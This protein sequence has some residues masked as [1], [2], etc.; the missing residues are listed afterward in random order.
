M[1]FFVYFKRATFIVALFFQMTTQAAPTETYRDLIE[2]AYNLSLQKDRSQATSI[3][4]NALKRETRPQA[5]KELAAALEQVAKVFYSEKGQQLYELA[6]SLKSTDLGLAA[7]KFQ[8]ANR[9]EPENVAIEI[10]SIRLLMAGKDCGAALGRL[11]GLEDLASHIEEIRLLKAQAT[12]CGGQFEEY[13]T[14][15]APQD[16]KKGPLLLYWQIVETEFLFKTGMF[17]KAKEIGQTIQKS[18]KNFPESSYWIWKVEIDLKQN[19]VPA[20]EK[21][22][23]L[24]KSLSVRQLRDYSM[25]P[26]LCRRTTEVETFLKKNNNSEL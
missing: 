14:L 1:Q 8:E 22:L 11:K 7:A 18:E 25:D 12:V 4:V 21:Y 3:L 9:L 5:Q 16:L 17:Q 23:A 20:G 10:E 19:A 6:M 13:R 26:S 24:C 15:K 2:K